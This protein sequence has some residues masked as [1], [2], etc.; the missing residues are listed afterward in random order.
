MK[1]KTKTEI[2]DADMASLT[3]ERENSPN[4]NTK[5]NHYIKK[6]TTM[7]SWEQGLLGKE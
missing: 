4:R 6:E 2:Q 5:E 7:D 3:D 1:I